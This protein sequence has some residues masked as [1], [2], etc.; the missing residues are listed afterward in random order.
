M[1]KF[2]EK[3]PEATK[4]KDFRD[5]ILAYGYEFLTLGVSGW[6]GAFANN[7]TFVNQACSDKEVNTGGCNF[8][9]I[10][11]DNKPNVAFSPVIN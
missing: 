9:F 11:E 5:L 1:K 6:S 3:F 8:I 7:N 2:V 4:Y 10:N